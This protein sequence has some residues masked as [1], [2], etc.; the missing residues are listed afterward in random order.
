MKKGGIK[1]KVLKSIFYT[2]ISLALAFML[3]TGCIA[4]V[5]NK[6]HM[7]YIK[8]IFTGNSQQQEKV[9]E[10]TQNKNTIETEN[11]VIRFNF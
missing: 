7:D 9:E 4:K 6:G 1:K 11:A 5:R 3:I 10:P 8:E 2:L